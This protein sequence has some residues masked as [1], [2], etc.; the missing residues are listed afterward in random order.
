MYQISRGV[1][2]GDSPVPEL[3]A[4]ILLVKCPDLERGCSPSLFM[5]TGSGKS[6]KGEA[7]DEDEETEYFDAMEEAPTFITVAAD[8]TKHRR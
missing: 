2:E 4:L 8:P 3:F 7:S 6:T 5:T 1:N